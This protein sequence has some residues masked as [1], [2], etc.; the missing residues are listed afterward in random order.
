MSTLLCPLCLLSP[1]SWCADGSF[2]PEQPKDSGQDISI[3]F[4]FVLKSIE[5]E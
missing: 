2:F 1:L 3:L 5:I 4:E